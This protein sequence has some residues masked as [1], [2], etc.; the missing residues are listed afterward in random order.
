MFKSNDLVSFIN[1][2]GNKTS[3][4][5]INTANPPYY[6]VRQDCGHVSRKFYT[7]AELQLLN[8]ERF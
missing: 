8:K 6:V 3:G 5:I 7:D 2:Y 1:E 4:H